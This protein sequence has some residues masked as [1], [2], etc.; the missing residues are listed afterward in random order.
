MKHSTT[1][2]TADGSSVT[3]RPRGAHG[4][5]LE[6]RNAKGETIATVVMDRDD[7]RALMAEMDEVTA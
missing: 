1:I 7:V 2:H 5:D 3:I 6:T 4:Y